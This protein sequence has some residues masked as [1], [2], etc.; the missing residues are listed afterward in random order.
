M[1]G[2]DC[3]CV[4]PFLFDSDFK[5]IYSKRCRSIEKQLKKHNIK[6][7]VSRHTLF[8]NE[9]YLV[10]ISKDGKYVSNSDLA[11][12]LRIPK[13][14]V[15]VYK[16]TD[17][18][19]IRAILEEQLNSKYCADED[20]D[21]MFEFKL[22]QVKNQSDIVQRVIDRM[23]DCGFAH[24]GVF[25]DSNSYQLFIKVKNISMTNRHFLKK[26]LGVTNNYKWIG[27]LYNDSLFHSEGW[28]YI[29]LRNVK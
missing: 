13:N 7:T 19:V 24:D 9:L 1:I 6:A 25:Y 21:L 29:N 26:I 14:W 27:T 2:N 23:D 3:I 20:S 4:P 18:G 17:D 12:V 8:D 15:N 5:S 10:D 22:S 16:H 11:D 28:F